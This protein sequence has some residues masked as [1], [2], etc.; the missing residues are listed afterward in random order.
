VPASRRCLPERLS[1]EQGAAF[2][3]NY[4]TAYAALV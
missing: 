4:G 3:V 1:F 2:P